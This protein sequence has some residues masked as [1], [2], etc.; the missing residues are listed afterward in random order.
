[1][2]KKQPEKDFSD[3]TVGNLT[4]IYSGS[5]LSCE[6]TATED[7]MSL[8]VLFTGGTEQKSRTIQIQGSSPVNMFCPSFEGTVVFCYLES[9]EEHFYDTLS[10]AL[11]SQEDLN[12]RS[13]QIHFYK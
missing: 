2:Q 13:G 8:K 10:G 1:M 6:I 9:G 5:E 12:K 3:P 4:V 11:L 7:A